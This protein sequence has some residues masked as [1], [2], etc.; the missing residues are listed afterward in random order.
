[1]K[2]FHTL[3]ALILLSGCTS[4]VKTK[5]DSWTEY[6][7]G[8]DRNHFSTLSEI[9]TTNVQQLKIAWTYLSPDSG[10]MQMNPIMVN[11]TVYG[12]T[13]GLKAF[14][15]D[16]ASGK[17][18][19]LFTDSTS[20]NG[21]SRGVAYWEDGNDKRIFYA[22]G[23]NLLALDAGNGTLISTFGDNGKVNLHTGLPESAKNK[24]ITSN[25]PGTIYKDFIIMPVRVGE[26]AG[27]APGDI[28]AFNVRT[29]E[30]IW[31]FHTIPHPGEMG[32]ETWPED[33]YKNTN[34]GAVN[35]WAGMAIDNKTGTLFI[36]LGSAA[37]DFYGGNRIG[38]NL[39]ANCLLA[40]NA[41]DGSYKWH[42]QTTHHDLWDRDLPAPP[43]LLTVTKN[44]K[45]I[46]AVAQI[47]KQGTVF[48]FNRETGEPLFPVEEVSAPTSTLSGEQSWPTQPVPVLPEPFARS[49]H[50]LTENDISQYAGNKEELLEIL[51]NSDKRLFAPPDTE[52]VLIL[53]GYD[54]GAEYGGAGAD[55]KNGIL[56]VNSNEMAWYLRME[57]TETSN[58]QY[59][60]NHTP[61]QQVYLNYCSVCHGINREGNTAS[62]Y[63]DLTKLAQTHTLQNTSEIIS[64]GKGKMPG[65]P[66][67]S[68]EEK[69]H[70]LAYLFGVEKTEA[71]SENLSSIQ[72]DKYNLQDII[73]S[74]TT[75]D[76]QQFRRPGEH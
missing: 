63:A 55:P 24:Y 48:V 33:A 22:V 74:L 2:I 39:F 49:A 70:L 38:A 61:G 35:N 45:Q 26:D 62:G 18:L 12:V 3:L 53:P 43:N 14:A 16:A 5:S 34:V 72:K 52:N 37:P 17:Q 4:S 31:T 11:S 69:Q 8:P 27:A 44:G 58:E 9:D 32:Y 75:M 23:E 21:V 29:G 30:L 25:T 66:I 67:I 64:N 68:K 42:F 15:L 13:A 65:F 56:Y 36:P 10:Q 50:E 46:D 73:N 7:G 60:N 71:V 41:N 20:S 19:W 54:G 59:E 6:L 40:L 57:K 47:T 1:M 76:Y 28:R 51:I